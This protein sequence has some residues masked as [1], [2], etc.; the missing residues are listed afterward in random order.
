MKPYIHRV[1]YYETDKMGITH[2][3]N[4]I[5]FME[6]ARLDYLDQI[7]YGYKRMEDEGLISPTVSVTA[8]YKKP[9]TFNDN[10]EIM[11][12][13]TKV[14]PARSFWKYEMKVSG[15]IVFEGT[16]SHCFVDKNGRPVS[17]KKVSPKLHELLCSLAT[18]EK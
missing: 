2:H 7:G 8:D 4:Y 5:R 15:E 3:S 14:T 13:I 6:E 10:I 9:T 11:V 16:T 1:Q 17:S 18:N 12:S